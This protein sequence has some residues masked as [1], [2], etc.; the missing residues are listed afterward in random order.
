VRLSAP[1]PVGTALRLGGRNVGTLTSSVVSPQLGPIGLALLRREAE[2]GAMLD[3]G[4]VS[5]T[6]VELP[7]ARAV[8]AH[9]RG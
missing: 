7:F 9:T 2:P 5:A 6:V 4:A 8:E 1:L 3:A